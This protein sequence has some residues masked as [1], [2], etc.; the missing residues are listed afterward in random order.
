MSKT[1]AIVF[2]G[3]RQATLQPCQPP[4]IKSTE[5]LIKTEYSGVSQGTEIWA[6]L[7]NR[8]E[9]TFPTVPG[10]QS[11]GIIEEVGSDA[12]GY[13]PGQRVLFHRSRLSENWTETWMGG[14]V[15][16]AAVP[17]DNDPPPV[18]IPEGVD[19]VA[20]TLSA[21]A[22]VSLRGIEMLDIQ[23]GDLVVV[24]GQGLIGQAAAQLAH[25]RGATVIATDIHAKR[26][27]LSQQYSADIVVNPMKENLGKVVRNI[28]PNGADAV[29]DT[30]GRSEAFAECIDLLRWEG[31]FLMQ[32]YYPKPITFDFHATHMKKP[33]IA[34]TCGIGDTVRTLE[35]MRTGKLNWRELVTHLVPVNEAPALYEKM[36]NADPEILGVV[37]DWKE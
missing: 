11:V 32:G 14:H 35:L 12:S 25:I 24:T 30:T 26:L 20:A 8:P 3:V 27:E 21:L 28:K 4:A 15:S 1:R 18:I 36:A 22:A 33:K 31:Q 17:I 23:F 9:L 2:P 10:Y 34:V 5:L 7:G 6:Y 37:F 13:E 16:L 29:I 19:P